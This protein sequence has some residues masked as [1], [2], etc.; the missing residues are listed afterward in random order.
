MVPMFLH[1]Q[2]FQIYQMI[3]LINSLIINFFF[4]L[5]LIIQPIKNYCFYYSYDFKNRFYFKFNLLGKFICLYFIL[6]L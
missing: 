2:G 5:T 6:L 4:F 3:D 1:L